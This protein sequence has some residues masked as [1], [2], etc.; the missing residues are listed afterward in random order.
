MILAVAHFPQGLKPA[1]YLSDADVRAE[2]RTLQAEARTLQAEARTLQAEARTLQ[3]EA[4]TLP[5]D[6]LR[7]SPITCGRC[8]RVDRVSAASGAFFAAR[9][10]LFLPSEGRFHVFFANFCHR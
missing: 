6:L 4:R 7:W 5:T 1:I 10:K 2:A 9:P 8:V 3:A